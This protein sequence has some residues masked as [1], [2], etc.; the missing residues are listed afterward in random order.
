MR[1][2]LRVSGGNVLFLALSIIMTLFLP[3]I[4]SVEDFGYWQ[5]FYFYSSFSGLLMFGFNDGIHLR[6]A[7]V[8]EN[9]LKNIPVG[10]YFIFNLLFAGILTILFLIVIMI[11]D[12]DTQRK[13]VFFSLGIY[14]WL[15]NINSFFN[16]VYLITMQF[17]KYSFLKYAQRLLF[18]ILLIV[19]I[20]TINIF[21]YKS[22]IFLY[23]GAICLLILLNIYLNYSIL[24]KHKYGTTIKDIVT[25]FKRGLPLT[26]AAIIS[27]LLVGYPRI[28][29]DN[30]FS[31]EIFS[32]YSLASSMLSML[33]TVILSISTVLYPKLKKKSKNDIGIIMHKATSIIAPVLIISFLSYFVFVIIIRNFLQQYIS[34]LDFI[35]FIMPLVYFQA[36][37][38]IIIVN[39]FK[40]YDLEKNLF[41]TNSM[42][43]IFNILIT[44]FV[45]SIYESLEV[46]AL[47]STITYG[48]FFLV[49]L[50]YVSNLTQWDYKKHHL[51]AD[52]IYM[53]IFIIAIELFHEYITFVVI[54]IS[55]IIYA[56]YILIIKK[57][58]LLFIGGRE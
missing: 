52:Y 51:W 33:I 43:L 16:H 1:D 13:I 7:G 46:I 11:I 10:N 40:I 17:K 12:I 20:L 38:N 14:L 39:L 27:M 44:Y 36:L 18:L 22:V 8:S 4:L 28:I 48:I 31:I 55:T 19:N 6:F 54:L 29:V 53:V 42:G 5:L 50:V 15:F 32:V 26:I 34:I 9:E 49:S 30:N 47:V 56:L 25:N 41:I 21:N 24:F 35:H 37:F 3:F 2:I 23:G 58:Y 45:F 57:Y